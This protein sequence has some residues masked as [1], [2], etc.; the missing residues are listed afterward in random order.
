MSWVD[1]D[2]RRVVIGAPEVVPA[3]EQASL[4]EEG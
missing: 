1:I 2:H 3:V 4:F